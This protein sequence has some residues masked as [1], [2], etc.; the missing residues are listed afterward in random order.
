MFA[1]RSLDV[2]L[3]ISKAFYRSNVYKQ[4]FRKAAFDYDRLSHRFARKTCFV[5]FFRQ[6]ARAFRITSSSVVCERRDVRRIA[7][8]HF[9]VSSRQ[10]RCRRA[11]EKMF[12]NQVARARKIVAPAAAKQ[13]KCASIAAAAVANSNSCCCLRVCGSMATTTTTTTT[14]AA[15][16]AARC[17][18]SRV[19]R[20]AGV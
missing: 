2:K 3:I 10:R 19:A 1:K 4:K 6:H 13:K 9:R 14:T 17:A 16:A 11:S 12:V 18:H 15:A 8:S 7:F 20:S 5:F